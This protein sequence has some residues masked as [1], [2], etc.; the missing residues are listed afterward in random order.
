MQSRMMGASTKV[1]IHSGGQAQWSMESTWYG[2]NHPNKP[3]RFRH[4]DRWSWSDPEGSV[5]RRVFKIY[6]PHSELREIAVEEDLSKVSWLEPPDAGM[7]TLLDCFIA[8][9]AANK[10]AG[11]TPSW[12]CVLELSDRTSVVVLGYVLRLTTHD[13]SEKARVFEE[14]QA[15]ATASDMIIQ[16]G[17]RLVALSRDDE[18]TRGMIEFVPSG[19]D[20]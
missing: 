19:S 14:V 12:I 3:N 1:S 10:I 8:P 9:A 5:A 4:I 7:Q 17:F 18:G 6:I 2:V 11:D 16:K 15:R 13:L 20:I